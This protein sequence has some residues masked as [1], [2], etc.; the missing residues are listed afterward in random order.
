MLESSLLLVY[1][2][3]GLEN[4]KQVEDID[5]IATKAC[6][7]GGMEGYEWPCYFDGNPKTNKGEDL[8]T[9]MIVM[10]VVVVIMTMMMIIMDA[11]AQLL[12]GQS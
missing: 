4:T 12:A 9:V 11:K 7:E 5:E 10:M 3:D 8:G 6:D 1:G 2:P